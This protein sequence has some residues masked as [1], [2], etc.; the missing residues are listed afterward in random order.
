MS[1]L[2]SKPVKTVQFTATHTNVAGYFNANSWPVQMQINSLGRNILIPAGEYIVDDAKP[3]PNKINDPSFETY[4]GAMSLS[5]EWAPGMI[6]IRFAN[7][8][9]VKPL[10][11]GFAGTTV[12]RNPEEF[13]GR[14]RPQPISAPL[15][16]STAP[17]VGSNPV[18]AMS[19]D[20]A[21]KNGLVRATYEPNRRSPKEVDGA[22]VHGEHLEEI[23]YARDLTPGEQSRLSKAARP[24]RPEVVEEARETEAAAGLKVDEDFNPDDPALLT[25]VSRNVVQRIPVIAHS[26]PAPVVPAPP[27]NL[28]QPNLEEDA[29][30]APRPLSTSHGEKRFI[31][32]IDGK[33]FNFRSELQRHMTRRYPEQVAEVMA[34][35]PKT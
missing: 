4:V 19:Y 21:R 35:Y 17:S 16:V 28:P 5:R 30:E 13:K 32:P 27:V 9:T 11:T 8:P 18:I 24:P 29:P 26:V 23:E 34:K 33:G 2:K 12:S 20:E 14:N 6:P 25:K 3:V 15:P 22:P 31:C 10:P 1:T 7:S